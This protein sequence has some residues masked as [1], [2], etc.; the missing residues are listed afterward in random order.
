MPL[1]SDSSGLVQSIST[2]PVRSPSC[3]ERFASHRPR[4]G[5]QNRLGADDRLHG[6]AG[7]RRPCRFCD[8]LLDLFA[9]R[10]REP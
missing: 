9:L 3:D 10:L 2:R 4:H 7:L 1:R 5:K 6:R 8:K